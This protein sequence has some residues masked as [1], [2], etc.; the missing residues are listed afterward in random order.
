MNTEDLSNVSQVRYYLDSSSLGASLFVTQD[1]GFIH[2]FCPFKFNLC[3]IS[4]AAAHLVVVL[5]NGS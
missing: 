1:L 3:T 2:I 5:S 4:L